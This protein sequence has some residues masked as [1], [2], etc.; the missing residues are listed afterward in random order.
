MNYQKEVPDSISID[1][2]P[3][4]IRLLFENKDFISLCEKLSQKTLEELLLYWSTVNSCLQYRDFNEIRDILNSEDRFKVIENIIYTNYLSQDDIPLYSLKELES[5]TK[6][7]IDYL[8][9]NR[10]NIIETGYPE[11]GFQTE[12]WLDS[13]LSRLYYV[14]IPH[15]VKRVKRGKGKSGLYNLTYV[16]SSQKF[17][18]NGLSSN[19]ERPPAIGIPYKEAPLLDGLTQQHETNL[20]TRERK[21]IF[22]LKI[23]VLKRIIELLESEKA[24][25]YWGE[26][27]KLMTD[28]LSPDEIDYFMKFDL[29]YLGFNIRIGKIVRLGGMLPGGFTNILIIIDHFDRECKTRTLSKVRHGLGNLVK[30]DDNGIP[31]LT[32]KHYLQK[33]TTSQKQT[34]NQALD[35]YKKLLKE[36]AS[37]L[38]LFQRIDGTLKVLEEFK[39][40]LR[41]R[42][43]PPQWLIEKFVEIFKLQPLE[44][45][46]PS[47]PKPDD[48]VF[49]FENDKWNI[50]F[51]GNEVNVK[52]WK[53][54]HHIAYLMKNKGKRISV[55]GLEKQSCKR[56]I[57][58]EAILHKQPMVEEHILNEEY[59]DF[60]KQSEHLIYDKNDL[61]LINNDLLKLKGMI[62][63]ENDP[64]RRLELKETYKDAKKILAASKNRFNRTREFPSEKEK[65]RIRVSARIRRVIEK[66]SEADESLGTH[67]ND[68]FPVR[69]HS[70]MYKPSSN[71]PWQL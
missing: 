12:H 27:W 43:R 42:C 52:D 14:K 8:E 24:C 69:G 29:F 11:T 5:I 15:D 59:S 7:Y 36:E 1:S 53:G 40:F 34:L 41:Y 55:K 48:Y 4:L 57:T 38:N 32:I 28:A 21:Q 17:F 30:C 22:D 56:Q 31:R 45:S 6:K 70:W 51:H 63:T 25:D 20:K 13:N 16:W 60:S 39:P 54:L 71:L 35:L 46:T 66:I 58:T 26:C 19:N 68:S 62:R 65:T 33:M 64:A 37:E 23:A 47:F 67:L 18:I 50:R 3:E 61:N 2:F 49:R 44:V 9:R 10:D